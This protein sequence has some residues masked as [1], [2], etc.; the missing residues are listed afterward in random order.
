MSVEPD[1]AQAESA[2]G[3]VTQSSSDW[4]RYVDDKI[5][6]RVRTKIKAITRPS[7]SSLQ[8]E[9]E[10]ETSIEDNNTD[11]LEPGR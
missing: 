10:G 11:A 2:K 1:A 6:L 9:P 3:T 7:A 5:A 4:I 8:K